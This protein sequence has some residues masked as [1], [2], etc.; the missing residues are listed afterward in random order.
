MQTRDRFGCT[1]K[2]KVLYGAHQ[3]VVSTMHAC[4]LY[5]SIQIG[6]VDVQSVSLVLDLGVTQTSPV[7]IARVIITVR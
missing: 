5:D 2:I 4:Q 3:A 6:T 7:P 1:P